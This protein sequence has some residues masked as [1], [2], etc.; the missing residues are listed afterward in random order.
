MKIAHIIATFPPYHGGMGYICYHNARVL[1]DRG[2]D[3]TVFTLEHGRLGYEGDPTTFRIE[4]MKP[5]LLHGDAG[6][7]PGL[8]SKL[9]KFDMLHLHYPFFGGAEYVYLTSVLKGKQYFL[10]Y[11]MD[12]H[13][14]SPLKKS[15]IRLYEP[16]LL[17]RIVQQAS[18]ICSP[19]VEYLRSTKAAPFIPWQLHTDVIYGGV[20]TD[21]FHPGPKNPELIEKHQLQGKVVVL[22]VG[23]L[24]PFKGLPLLIEAVRNIRNESIVLLVVGGGYHETAYRE[25]VVR[26]RL[27]N[28]IIFAGPQSPRGLLPEYYNLADFLV[29][30]STHSESF[31]LVVLEAMATGKPAI[32]SSLPGPSQLVSPGH[33]GHIVPIGDVKALSERIMDLAASDEARR[34]MGENARQKIQAHYSWE[35]IGVQLESAYLAIR[36]R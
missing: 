22:F 26:E 33:D 16:L 19:G 27:Q 20:D 4:R 5:L 14:D 15:V 21:L 12:V 7:V 6:M 18:G 3:V 30:P 34:W 9:P 36:D 8:V 35:K 17:K 1:A 24:I 29:L 10:T 31:G 2:H 25:M 13:G 28:R 32:V 23:N 11:H